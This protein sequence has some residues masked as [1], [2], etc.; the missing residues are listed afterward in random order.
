VEQISVLLDG[1]ARRAVVEGDY[2]HLANLRPGTYRLRLDAEFLPLEVVPDPKSYVVEV[3][4]GAVTDVRLQVEREYAAAGRITDGSGIPV[5]DAL[6]EIN[7]PEGFLRRVRSDRFGLY[8]ID[9]LAP[10]TYTVT[11]RAVDGVAL[12]A[13]PT[14]ALTV[15]D[16]FLFNQDLVLARPAPAQ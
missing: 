11:V 16:D 13:A 12:T 3:G 1:H 10:G 2:F 6:I 5:A 7:G 14:R 9:G 8:R 15:V 4:S